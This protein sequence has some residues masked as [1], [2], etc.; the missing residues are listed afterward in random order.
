MSTLKIHM[1]AEELAA[2][3]RAA[4]RLGIKPE[5]L[6]YEALDRLMLRLNEPELR[7]DLV[8]TVMSRGVSLALWSDSAHSVHIYESMPDDE[9]SPSHYLRLNEWR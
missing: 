5:A 4:E 1:P 8:K 7:S 3:N 9:S 2:V 6:A